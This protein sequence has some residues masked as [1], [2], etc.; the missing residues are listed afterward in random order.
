MEKASRAGWEVTHHSGTDT[1]APMRG[2]TTNTQKSFHVLLTRAGPKD[3][4]TR[5]AH[6]G[7][8]FSAVRMDQ[9]HMQQAGPLAHLVGLMEQPSTGM[10][11]VW[12]C[13]IAEQATCI[14][15]SIM[16]LVAT[17]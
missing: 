12:P 8:G 5:G 17:A 2:P 15:Q 4:H 11:T 13:T 14:G 7:P 3:L 6:V 1:T 9:A 10:S 16:P